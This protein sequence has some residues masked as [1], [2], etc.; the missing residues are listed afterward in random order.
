[1]LEVMKNVFFKSVLLT[2]L[3]LF[4]VLLIVSYAYYLIMVFKIFHQVF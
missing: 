1:M 2:P 3:L 4:V